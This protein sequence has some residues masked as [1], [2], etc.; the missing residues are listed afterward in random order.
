DSPLRGQDVRP[1]LPLAFAWLA[2]LW[3]PG[4]G[5]IWLGVAAALAA[6]A[7]TRWGRLAILPCAFAAAHG[8]VRPP[9]VVEL[10]GAGP[11]DAVVARAAEVDPQTRLR[12]VPVDIAGLRVAVADASD[13]GPVPLPGDRV[14]FLGEIRVARGYRN[15]GVRPGP[16]RVVATARPPGIARLV[17]ERTTLWRLA[18]SAQQRLAA[19][20]RGEGDGP[21][22][23]RALVAGDRRALAPSLEDAFRRTGTA[24]VLSVSGLHLA[25][26][27]GLVFLLLRRGI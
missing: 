21:A 2:G 10:A 18:A 19:P 4:G 15:P 26:V 14:R 3:V 17:G 5:P 25:A 23:V 24:H 11:H 22:L 8:L 7:W 12:R 6:L 16:P 20:F 1:V 27:S 9:P 13:R